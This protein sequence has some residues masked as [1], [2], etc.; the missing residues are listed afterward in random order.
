MTQD[1]F[2]KR[3][4]SAMKDGADIADDLGDDPGVQLPPEYVAR[5]GLALYDSRMT[6]AFSGVDEGEL[7]EDTGWGSY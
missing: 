4:R 3:L 1:Y 6:L 7:P 2:Y 5:M